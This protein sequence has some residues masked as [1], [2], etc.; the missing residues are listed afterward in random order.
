M[1][2]GIEKLGRTAGGYLRW[3]GGLTVMLG[4]TL[5]RGPRSP[6]GRADIAYQLLRLGVWSLPLASLMAGF[7]GMI[8][9]WQFGEAFTDFG[10]KSTL[11]NA[12]SLALVRELVPSMMALTVGSK[13]ATGMTA[14]L[15][16]MKVT[17]QIDAIAA[18]GADPLKKLVWPR[19]VAATIAMP[20][21][22]AWGNLLALLGGMIIS[23]RV[24][25]VPAGYFASTYIEELNVLDY[26]CTL[27][28]ALTFGGISGI[29]GCYQGFS[30]KFGTEAVG[31]ST[32]ETVAANSI[33][34][35]IAD[36]A[37]TT[38]FLPV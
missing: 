22:V 12:S 24:F 14:E 26:L 34:I 23:D 31:L 11:G 36:F 6:L 1:R 25:D 15:G 32:T 4:Q 9:A 7:V 21:L 38:L 3:A 33:A 10:A 35:V 16:S 29:V 19:L 20:L 13:M 5:V 2:S 8:L 28:K 27:T 17:E 37:L 18:L 30:T